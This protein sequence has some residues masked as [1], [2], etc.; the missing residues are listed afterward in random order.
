MPMSL[1]LFPTF[2]FKFRSISIKPSENASVPL[3][4]EKKEI[5]GWGVK[6]G[7]DLGGKGTREGKRET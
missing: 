1:R 7:K 5:T 6:G 3:G 2:S 4:R